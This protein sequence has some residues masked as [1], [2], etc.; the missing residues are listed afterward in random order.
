MSG[1]QER[2]SSEERYRVVDDSV[3][4]WGVFDIKDK[5]LVAELVRDK[6]TAQKICDELN[7][8]EE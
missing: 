3:S 1:K 5:K 4:T 8:E 7:E 2:H 6:M